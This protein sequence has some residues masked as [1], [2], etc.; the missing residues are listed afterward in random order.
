MKQK[1]LQTMFAMLVCAGASA[2]VNSGSNGSDGA[3][4]PTNDITIDM[5]DHL[6]DGSKS[7]SELRF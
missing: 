5:S 6:S 3:L 7:V 2:Q 1:I 4:N